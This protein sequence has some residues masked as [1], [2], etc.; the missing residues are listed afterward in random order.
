MKKDD[1]ENAYVLYEGQ[2]LTFKCFQKWN[3]SNK[4]NK[5]WRT[6]KQMLQR[7]QIALA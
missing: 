2:E 1:Y 4:T 3:I 7:L 5:R 6:P